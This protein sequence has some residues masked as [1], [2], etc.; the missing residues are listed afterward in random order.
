M[1][2]AMNKVVADLSG[3]DYALVYRVFHAASVLAFVFL[4][5]RALQIRDSLMLAVAPLALTVFF[6]IHTFLGTVKEIYPTNH[7]LQVALLAMLALNLTQSKRG[8][9]VDLALWLTFAFAA[10]TLNRVCW[11]GS[12]SRVPGS[13]A[14]PVPRGAR[15]PARRCFLPPTP[16]CDSECSARACRRLR[17]GVRDISWACFHPSRSG[18]ASARI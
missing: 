16:W 9:L 1:Y 7:F 2:Y 10:L 5:V 8:L 15:S 14:C 6:G 13:L 3:G 4:F 12:S 11:C 17:S 18:R